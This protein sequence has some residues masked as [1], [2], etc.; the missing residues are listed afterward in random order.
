VWH[1]SPQSGEEA[2][3]NAEEELKEEE[4]TKVTVVEAAAEEATVPGE[5]TS[6]TVTMT[7]GSAQVV[8][9]DKVTLNQGAAGRVEARFV[10]VKSGAVGIAHGENIS[11]VDGAAGV[12]G[13]E[14]IK[15]QDSF[16]LFA[17]ANKIEGEDT[18][19]LL[20]MRAAAVF[21]LV[22]GGVTSLFKLITHRR[23]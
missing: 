5:V 7:Q 19:V 18:A 22:L 2:H 17:A 9:A 11:I 3:V 4:G 21:A 16:V 20:D 8:K 1:N 23:A 6:E 10:D 13:A 14:N 12:L 15:V